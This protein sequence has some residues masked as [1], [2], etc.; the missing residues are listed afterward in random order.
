MGRACS[1]YGGQ[2]RGIHD[3]GEETRL[4][5]DHLDDLDVDGRIIL[6]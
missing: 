6:K 4:E 3:F 5:R 2:D 1:S